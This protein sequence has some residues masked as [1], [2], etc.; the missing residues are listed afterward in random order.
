MACRDVQFCAVKLGMH[1][2]YCKLR[3]EKL[4]QDYIF[5]NARDLLRATWLIA[6][7][8]SVLFAPVLV[9]PL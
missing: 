7:S 3:G 2:N 8:D 1:R 9:R 5:Y 4:Y 6:V